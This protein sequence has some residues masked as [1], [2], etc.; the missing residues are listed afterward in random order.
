MMNV[1]HDL[2][3][4]PDFRNAVLTIGSFDGVHRGHQEILAKINALAK[5]CGGES[6][7]VTFHPHPR[8]VVYPKDKSL[9]LLTSVAEKIA[10][11]ERFDVNHVVVVPFTVEFSQQDADEYIEKFLVGKFN[12]KY[13]VIGYD[14]RFGLNRKGNIDFIKHHAKYHDFEVVEIQKQEVEAITVSSTK[15]RSALAAGNVKKAS[16]LLGHYF[17][18]TGQVVYGRQLGTTIGFPTANLAIN[19]KHKLLPPDGIYAVFVQHK[20]QR[21]EGMLYIGNRPSIADENKRSI[22]VNIFDFDQQIY[23]DQIKL[24]LV[25]F[26]RE[27]QTFDGVEALKEQLKLDEKHVKD[28]LA[29]LRTAA[30]KTQQAQQLTASVAIVILNYNG[31][32]HLEEF[33]PSVLV[34]TYANAEIYVAD[35]A[36]TDDSVEFLK[37]QFPEVKLILLSENYGFAEG[38]NQALKMVE[39]DYFILL[40]SDVAV[41]PDWI[42]PIIELMERDPSV[43]V[44]QPKILSHSRPEYFEHAGAAGGW[45]DRLNYPFCRGRI[46]DRVEKDE[47]QYDD[48]Q[49]VFWCSGAAFFIRSKR[50]LEMGG[51]EGHFFAHLEEI[52]LCW[53]LKR[54]G[55]KI[56]VS[57]KS[58][59]Y[60]LGGG[61][62]NYGN[63]RKT[64]LNFRNS[65][66]TIVRNEERGQVLV[67]VFTRLVL[68]GVAGAMFLLQGELKQLA[69]IFKAHWSFFPKLPQLL[70]ER[71][72]I[73]DQTA[74][75]SIQNEPNLAGKYQGSIVWQF[76]AKRK[77]TF[78]ELKAK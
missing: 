60:H 58:V 66:Y 39:A 71:R 4:L 55:Y 78:N 30:Q 13:M 1:Y 26:I 61:A 10:L 34:T 63:P 75:L 64:Y 12:P 21:Y 15:I 62:L 28:N 45:M 73:R 18:L 69:A 76:Y 23:G 53:R 36:S 20:A 42:A 5:E 40:N 29:Y 68:D 33:L 52:D 37:A 54:A 3:N 31:R 14:H 70:R 16:R 43:A 59:V 50:Y 77:K 49:E 65:L 38:Y 25:D 67:K 6:I 11:F 51:F 35:N 17:T 44:C 41:T 32:Q 22:E 8:L 2:Q 57:P 56:M 48:I 72:R 19:S 27:G 7:V 47:G 74:K 46:F 24:E 9:R